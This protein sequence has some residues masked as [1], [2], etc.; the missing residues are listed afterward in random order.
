MDLLRFG[1]FACSSL[2]FHAK[3]SISWFDG[4]CWLCCILLV[5]LS[6]ILVCHCKCP[7]WFYK[8]MP[9]FVSSWSFI[10]QIDY[11]FFFFVKNL[12]FIIPFAWFLARFN[13][14]SKTPA[15]SQ[16]QASRWISLSF[17]LFSVFMNMFMPFV[18]WNSIFFFC[19]QRSPGIS[20]VVEESSSSVGTRAVEEAKNGSSSWFGST[21]LSRTRSA[22]N[23]LLQQTG[24]GKQQAW[25]ICHGNCLA[26]MWVI[27]LMEELSARLFLTSLNV[28]IVN[29]DYQTGRRI[30]KFS[31]ML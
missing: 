28:F 31:F 9:N 6:I 30:L 12:S 13:A 20:G 18:T 24:S 7:L 19:F 27:S 3:V 16:P 5:R 23:A 4:M 8:F 26:Y 15:R 22:T 10:R 11:S 17:F 14:P 1:T 29:I 25:V 2:V 21:F